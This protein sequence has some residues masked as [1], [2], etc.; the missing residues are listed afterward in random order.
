LQNLKVVCYFGDLSVDCWRQARTQGRALS[1]V[2]P[3][4]KLK[5]CRLRQCQAFY[6]SAEISYKNRLMTTSTLEF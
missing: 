1:S 2:A 3:E 6:I 4:L 5:K